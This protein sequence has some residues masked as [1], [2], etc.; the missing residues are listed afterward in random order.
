MH[1]SYLKNIF[2]FLIKNKSKWNIKKI[3]YRLE[4]IMKTNYVKEYFLC[5]DQ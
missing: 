5:D 1:V 4:I 2:V 3:A